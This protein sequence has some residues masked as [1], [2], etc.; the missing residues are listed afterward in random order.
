MTYPIRHVAAVPALALAALALLASAGAA[1][2]EVVL[3][4]YD[5]PSVKGADPSTL[6]GKVMTGYQGW[7]NCP[8]D[9]SNLGWVHWGRD[10]FE[11]GN[12]TVDLWPDLSEYDDDELYDTGF[13]HAD[14]SVAKVFSSH[15]RKTVLRHFKWMQDYGIDGAFVQRFANGLKGG[16]VRYH[17]D[18]VLSSAREGAN[19]YG[20]TYTIMYDLTGIPDEDI[21]KV[22][23]DWRMLREQMKITEDPAFQH[24][25]GKPLVALWGVGF[26]NEIK[27]RPGFAECTELLQKFKADGCSVLLGIATGWREQDRDA[28]Q[29]PDLHR[30]LQMA[31]VI[32]PWS[33]GRFGTLDG[34]EKHAANYWKPDIAWAREHGVDYMPVIFPG[35]S[36]HNLTK[37]ESPLAHIPRL[38][39]QFLWSQAVA[40]KKAGADMIYIAMFD[41]VDEATAIF[42]CSDQPPTGNGGKFLTM[43]GL[44][45]DYYLRM[46]GQVGQLLRNEIAVSETVPSCAAPR[47][48][49]L[50]AADWKITF[51]V[52]GEKGNALEMKNPDFSACISNDCTFPENLAPYVY[53]VSGGVAFHTEY[54][55]VTTSSKTKYSRTEL[56]EMNGNTEAGWTLDEERTMNARLKIAALAGGADKLFFMQIHGMDPASEPLLKCIWEKGYIRLLTK[57]GPRL[58]DFSRQPKYT[59][60]GLDEWFTCS[61]HVDREALSIKINGETIETYGRDVLDSWPEG[62]TYYFKAGNYLQNNTPGA[63]STVVFS[64]LAITKNESPNRKN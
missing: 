61:I 37:G 60:V 21:V 40:N 59:A 8:G 29:D 46:A 33:V 9:G 36:W 35:F 55:G 12:I 15:N 45:S 27:R 30:V 22:F 20:R 28:L 34:V 25:N 49:V 31:D 24:H 57:S 19:R 62:N 13:R 42:K 54:T 44:P 26:N 2:R 39:G 10:G 16:D 11:P 38:K 5:G 32:S 50:N 18:K 14:G 47:P 53:P 6:T 64:S 63:S 41:E 43:E 52:A 17:K 56:R 4:P 23:D 58:K 7:F 51:P 48:A 1:P 3:K